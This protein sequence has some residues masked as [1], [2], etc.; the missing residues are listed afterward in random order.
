MSRRNFIKNLISAVTFGF[1]KLAFTKAIDPGLHHANYS[2]MG[3][4]SLSHKVNLYYDLNFTAFVTIKNRNYYFY[5]NGMSWLS[6]SGERI[7]KDSEQLNIDCVVHSCHGDF[8]IELIYF[9]S[10]SISMA[11]DEL[12]ENTQWIVSGSYLIHEGFVSIHDA[13]YRSITADDLVG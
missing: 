9:N 8:D 1:S 6:A 5:P 4:E 10:E 12:T 3:N 11:M 2:I 13:D 7:E